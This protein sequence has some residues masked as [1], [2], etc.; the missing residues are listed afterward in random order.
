MEIL[1]VEPPDTRLSNDPISKM[2]RGYGKEVGKLSYSREDLSISIQNL[3]RA[4]LADV[5]KSKSLF[6]RITHFFSQPIDP[7]YLE[8]DGN[9]VI[10]LL[11]SADESVPDNVQ[12]DRYYKVD[13]A[14]LQK[15]LLKL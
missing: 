5:E 1:P 10:S 6:G 11:V 12:I 14:S 7:E 2:A 3:L 9:R 8:L 15:L 13:I 4:H